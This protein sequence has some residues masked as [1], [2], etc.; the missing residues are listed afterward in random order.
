MSGCGV[1]L[2][3]FTEKIVLAELMPEAQQE[4]VA[5]LNVYV[6]PGGK[7]EAV[8]EIL[9]LNPFSGTIVIE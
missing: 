4:T 9:P 8:S 1:V 6:P 7:F 2:E 5:G 3:V